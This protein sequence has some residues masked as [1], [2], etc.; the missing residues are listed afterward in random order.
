MV[1]HLHHMLKVLMKRLLNAS[2]VNS[3]YA[4]ILRIA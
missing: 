4:S 2:L 3:R 1:P